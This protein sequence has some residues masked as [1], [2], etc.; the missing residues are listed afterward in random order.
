M[1]GILVAET[2]NLLERDHEATSEVLE[3]WCDVFMLINSSN[4][5]WQC[6][7]FFVV[8][9]VPVLEDGQKI[10]LH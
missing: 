9:Q 6:F 7:E 2:I 1:V 10:V 4:S 8:S 5:M 3:G